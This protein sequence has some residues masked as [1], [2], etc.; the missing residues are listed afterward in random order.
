M[1][2]PATREQNVS[3]TERKGNKG[4]RPQRSAADASW[5]VRLRGHCQFHPLNCRD[6]LADNLCG[7]PNRIIF[8]QQSNDVL[9]FS[10]EVVA[11]KNRR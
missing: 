10:E 6:T 4:A 5:N 9:V 2:I 11:L 7:I 8:L 3:G 1:L